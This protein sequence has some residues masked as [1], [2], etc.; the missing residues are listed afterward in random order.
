MKVHL[1]PSKILDLRLR[2]SEALAILRLARGLAA[3]AL[4]IQANERTQASPFLN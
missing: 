1:P 2:I 4:P 3:L